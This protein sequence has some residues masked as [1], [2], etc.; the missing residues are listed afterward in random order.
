M[1]RCLRP[2][3]SNMTSMLCLL[4][5]KVDEQY[6][7]LAYLLVINSRGSAAWVEQR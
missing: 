6:D 5:L 3:V 4:E 2:F 1:A 7:H